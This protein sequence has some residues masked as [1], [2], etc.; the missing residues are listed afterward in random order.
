M[1]SEAVIEPLIL[2]SPVDGS[3]TWSVPVAYIKHLSVSRQ[4]GK[5]MKCLGTLVY[6][7]I[8]AGNTKV[9]SITV[10]LTSCLT[11]LDSSVLQ[12]ECH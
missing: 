11:G 9:G 10:L 6:S 4:N 7:I 1:S 3:T 8:G 12:T 2:G 5:L